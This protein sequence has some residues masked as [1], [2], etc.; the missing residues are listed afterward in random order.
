SNNFNLYID[1]GYLY[2]PRLSTH[3]NSLTRIPL[4]DPTTEEVVANNLGGFM[5]LALN[6]DWIYAVDYINNKIVKIHKTTKTEDTFLNLNFQPFDIA[7]GPNDEMYI[8]A[9]GEKSIYLYQDN[10]LTKIISDLPNLTTSVEVDAF[11]NLIVM[12]TNNGIRKYTS[13]FSSFEQISSKTSN[14]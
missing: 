9:M 2:I 11:G 8:S 4:A 12:I 5:S 1:E 3:T 10:V 7:F 6:G 13:D 14:L